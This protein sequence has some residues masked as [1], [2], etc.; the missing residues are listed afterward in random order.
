[1]ISRPPIRS[2]TTLASGA[3]GLAGQIVQVAFAFTGGSWREMFI[4]YSTLT[5]ALKWL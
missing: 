5:A 1:L 2:L 4:G 3:V